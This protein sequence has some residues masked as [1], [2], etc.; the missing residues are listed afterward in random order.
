MCANIGFGCKVFVSRGTKSNVF[1]TMKVENNIEAAKAKTNEVV[2]P[3]G[4]YEPSNVDA[5]L[6]GEFMYNIVF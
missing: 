2:N 4:E 1:T 3:M 5:P 6:K